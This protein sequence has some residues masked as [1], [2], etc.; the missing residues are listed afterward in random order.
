M[1]FNDGV[2]LMEEEPEMI[3]A[4]MSEHSM[5]HKMETVME[6]SGMGT[7]SMDRLI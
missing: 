4:M 2:M 1:M 3:P 6:K 5:M 7:G